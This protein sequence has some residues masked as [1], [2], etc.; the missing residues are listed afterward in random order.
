MEYTCFLCKKKLKILN[1]L[2]KHLKFDELI[3]DNTQIGCFLNCNNFF[4]SI[5]SAKQHLKACKEAANESTEE[6]QNNAI[7]VEDDNT[8]HAINLDVR[9]FERRSL[10]LCVHGF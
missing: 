5:K 6:H 2:I 4:K 8:A 10:I 3:T 7:L 9:V 1:I